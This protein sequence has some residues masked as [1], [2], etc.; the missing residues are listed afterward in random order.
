M[1]PSRQSGQP[2]HKTG[3]ATQMLRQSE[4]GATVPWRRTPTW[5]R[6][7]MS[8]PP[9]PGTGRQR[10]RRRGSITKI[11]YWWSHVE[12]WMEKFEKENLPS[13]L[14]NIW[15][16]SQDKKWTGFTP[17]H[18][19][20]TNSVKRTTEK[21]INVPPLNLHLG[22]GIIQR[23]GKRRSR[24]Q[25]AWHPPGYESLP[26]ISILVGNRIHLKNRR[27]IKS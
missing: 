17:V 27:W 21:W 22:I 24:L 12:D 26:S 9:T 6:R 20:S 16:D 4:V 23:W 18:I 11:D 5:C 10:W 14:K 19:W 25:F 7:M 3:N 13:P 8:A 2:A 1:Y 15:A